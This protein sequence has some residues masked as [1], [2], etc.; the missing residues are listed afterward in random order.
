MRQSPD[1]RVA[2][3]EVSSVDRH[4]YEEGAGRS[5]AGRIAR[6]RDRPVRLSPVRVGGL[7]SRNLFSSVN[8]P[9]TTSILIGLGSSS[10]PNRPVECAARVESQID[11]LEEV[12]GRDRRAAELGR[13]SDRTERSP[14]ITAQLN[15]RS[16]RTLRGPG[17]AR[18]QD[19]SSAVR[20]EIARRRDMIRGIGRRGPSILSF[21][22]FRYFQHSDRPP[23]LR[24]ARVRSRDST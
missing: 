14:S 12:A 2:H 4:A 20:P 19:D 17:T 8:P 11:V 21:L 18:D 13:D 5:G 1:R 3:L 6:N 7:V 10:G 24:C 22:G 16:S 9:W 23:S 15:A